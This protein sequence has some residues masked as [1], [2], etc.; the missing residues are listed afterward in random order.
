M[1]TGYLR[2]EMMSTDEVNEFLAEH[3]GNKYVIRKKNEAN[4]LVTLEY[5]GEYNDDDFSCEFDE[6]D[7]KE[8]KEEFE[9][10]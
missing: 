3:Q 9:N 4:G 8:L 5:Y 1:K 10:K 6:E 2:F 7:Y